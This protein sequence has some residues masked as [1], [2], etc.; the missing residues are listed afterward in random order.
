MNKAVDEIVALIASEA[1]RRMKT[2]TYQ[3][4]AAALHEVMMEV[5]LRLFV[6]LGGGDE[7]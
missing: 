6:I 7:G 2:V 5:G 1:D 3:N 4:R